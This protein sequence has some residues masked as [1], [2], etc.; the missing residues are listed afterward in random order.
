MKEQEIK[1][2]TDIEH[3]L[4]RPQMYI[5]QTTLKYYRRIYHQRW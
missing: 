2:L 5:G 4:L 3:V 1:H